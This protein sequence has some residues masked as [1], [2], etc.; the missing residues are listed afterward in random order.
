M[1]RVERWLETQLPIRVKAHGNAANTARARQPWR[2]AW[3]G[4]TSLSES[5]ETAAGWRAD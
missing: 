2:L 5:C 4:E 3:K 1:R